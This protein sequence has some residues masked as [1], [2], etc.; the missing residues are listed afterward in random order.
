M[1]SRK[2][3]TRI[4]LGGLITGGLIGAV[5]GLLLAPESGKRLRRSLSK[6]ADE[7]IDDTGEVLEN[8]G[9]IASKIIS[10]AKKQA[11]NLIRDGKKKIEDMVKA[12]EN[13]Y[14]NGKSLAE[15]KAS[16]IR[17]IF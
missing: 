15:E 10:D 9:D 14:K 12:S 11:D 6:K 16:K 17:N 5:A 3:D 8:A 13:I 4:F 1:Y 7:I 2:K